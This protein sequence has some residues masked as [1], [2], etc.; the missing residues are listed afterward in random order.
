MNGAKKKEEKRKEIKYIQIPRKRHVKV[1]SSN[2]FFYFFIRK[3]LFYFFE[4]LKNEW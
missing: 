2:V 3:F 1:L 4:E